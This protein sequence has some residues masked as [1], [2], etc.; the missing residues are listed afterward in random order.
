MSAHR[1]NR[2]RAVVTGL[3]ANKT[4]KEIA[5]E[6]GISQKTVEYHWA[7][8][9]AEFNLDSYIAACLFALRRGWIDKWGKIRN[10]KHE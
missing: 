1:C 7:K 10:A 9:K 8:A 4:I 5:L 6:T 2:T 3:A